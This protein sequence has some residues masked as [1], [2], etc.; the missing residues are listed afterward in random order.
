MSLI[1]RRPKTNLFGRFGQ[2]RSDVARV[3]PADTEDWTAARRARPL[4]DLLPITRRW[5]D[6]LPE[7][8]RPYQLMKTYPRIANRLANGW[9]DR[10]GSRETLD[11]LLLDRRGARRGF[12]PFVLAEILSLREL[13]ERGHRLLSR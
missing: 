4:D 2:L 5:A 8:A 11:D 9:H 1:Y 3:P 6:S 13:L 12:P 10:P 7:S